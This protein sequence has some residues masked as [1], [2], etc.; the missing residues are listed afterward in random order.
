M[1]TDGRLVDMASHFLKEL[2]EFY[3]RVDS[4]SD[5]RTS[6]WLFVPSIWSPVTIVITYLLLVWLVPKVMR[7]REAFKLT[8]L[9]VIYNAALTLLNLYICVEL[10]VSIVD[11]GYSYSCQEFSMSYEPKE[12]RIA[13]VLWWFYFSKIVELF[14]TIFFLLRK[15]NNQVTY[16]HV[17]HHTTMVGLWWIGLKWVAG[18][19]SFF[20]ATLNSM[21]HVFMY[22]YYGMSA[23]PSL[24]KYLWWKKHLTQL[25][26]TQFCV[27]LCHAVVSLYVKCNYPLWMQYALIGYMI[28]FLVLFS[29]FYIHAYFARKFKR[30]E[31]NVANGRLRDSA[32]I[33]TNGEVMANGEVIAN[34]MA[35]S[36]LEDRKKRN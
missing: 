15:K 23:V 28:S 6:E 34:G 27:I 12:M 22:T 5:P 35:S 19:Q 29:N 7:S 26:L 13:S 25:Q 1:A 32:N 2:Q 14:D 21:V 16:L 11:A 33:M 20:S 18:G 31:K 30:H 8:T 3:V 9:L 36:D 24:R 4:Q 17:Y 10:L